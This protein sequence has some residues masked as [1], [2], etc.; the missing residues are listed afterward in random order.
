VAR[1]LAKVR[2][3]G[4]VNLVAGREVAPEFIQ[5]RARADL[6]A[7]ALLPLLVEGGATRSLQLDGLREVRARLGT[8]GASARA[9]AVARSLLQ[10]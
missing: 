3:I 7:E 4:L 1:F 9:A 2:W 5:R 8:P 6:L 10:P